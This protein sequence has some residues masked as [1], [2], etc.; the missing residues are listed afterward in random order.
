M[1]DGSN[2]QNVKVE[3]TGTLT[4]NINAPKGTDVTLGGGGVF[5]KLEV[6]RQVQM[7]P[8]QGGIGHA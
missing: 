8:A 1:I 4:A 7:M 3:G 6:N 5:K 2:T